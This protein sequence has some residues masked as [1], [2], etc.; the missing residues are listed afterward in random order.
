MRKIILTTLGTALLALAV[1][2]AAS[3]TARHHARKVTPHPTVGTNADPRDSYAEF[4][5]A[6]RGYD[7]RLWGG[8]MSAPAG[9]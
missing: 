9:R 6:Y 8:A 3:A 2:N 5:P 4:G 7:A 1:T